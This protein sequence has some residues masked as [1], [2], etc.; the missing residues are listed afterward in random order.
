MKNY[1]RYQSLVKEAWQHYCKS[2]Y[3]GTARLLEQSLQYTPYL[4]AET[5]S[6]WVTQ[7]VQLAKEGGYIF[8]A[9]VLSNL[10]EWNQVL[11]R[12]TSVE[13]PYINDLSGNK[14]QDNQDN[15]TY[16]SQD[17]SQEN[18]VE[19]AVDD[20]LDVLLTCHAISG[21]SEIE[22]AAVV[23]WSFFDSFGRL[24]S[25]SYEGTCISPKV[26][27]YTYL[28]CS[29]ESCPE[30]Q[31]AIVKVPK[32]A[33]N[34]RVE[35][36][37]WKNNANFSIKYFNV[38]LITLNVLRALLTRHPI[39]IENLTKIIQH[40]RKLGDIEMAVDL[41]RRSI[42][43]FDNAEA[44]RRIELMSGELQE[45]STSWKPTI[46]GKS[47]LVTQTDQLTVCH[48]HKVA[49]PF[50]NSG[51]SI[52]NLNVVVSQKKAGIDPYVILPL[53]YPPQELGKNM[54]NP[55]VN[56]EVDHYLLKNKG[57]ISQ[58][59]DV[60]KDRLLE[61]DTLRTASIIKSRGAKLI[62]A[63]SGFRGYELAL[64]GL[65]LREH[66]D[67]PL[68]YE[69][70]SFHEHTWGPYI[71]NIL[72]LKLTQKRILQENRC[73]LESDYVITISEA[74]RDKLIKR[75]VPE[76]KIAVIPNAINEELF[77]LSAT[78]ELVKQ[79]LNLDGLVCGYIS[80]MSYREGHEILIKAFA[81]ARKHL[82][83]LKCLLVGDGAERANLEKL[84]R[85]MDIADAV[86][87]TGEVDHSCIR[88]YY[89][90]I[91]IF[92]V[93]RRID[94]AADFVT[95]LKPYEAL[96]LGCPLIV[97]DRPA[98]REIVGHED[99]G[100]LF[101][102][103]SVESLASKIIALGTSPGQRKILSERG[104]KWVFEHRTWKKNAERY[105][106]VYEMLLEQWASSKK[107]LD[108]L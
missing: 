28:N 15:N 16:W 97:S 11:T 81:Q 12:A 17:K 35:I 13:I 24:L 93:P 82:P 107:I 43:R 86:R 108:F 96:A 102:T 4:K 99:R 33:R 42:S 39:R 65:A 84:A 76:D 87:F 72:E 19:L 7:L 90:A 53:N 74:M 46:F 45:L 26:G 79:Q 41:L 32:S 2:D 8:D 75:G 22:K 67:I 105:R 92:V 10:P 54:K 5:I 51:G 1:E 77:S 9:D 103:G 85:Q 64:K 106:Q 62:H 61:L 6:D 23:C 83:D 48:L 78:G 34:L 59:T 95:P 98:L 40:A 31:V 91:D 21:N 18:T 66:L 52:R 29:K 94:Y 37:K 44:H 73:M 63:V 69:V 38:E 101:E 30:T 27:H 47:H 25:G 36:R 80:N 20:D 89:A 57:K 88:D 71:P 58:P 3:A 49:Y 14:S 68:I 50:E 100:L 56:E 55:I 60:P 104:K 70:R